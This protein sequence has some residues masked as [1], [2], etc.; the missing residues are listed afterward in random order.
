MDS[1]YYTV[2]LGYRMFP[3]SQKVLLNIA[4]PTALQYRNRGKT[5]TL[6]G[7]QALSELALPPSPFLPWA[8]LYLFLM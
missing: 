5:H 4:A 7:L 2:Q 6:W 1:G 8:T 3:S